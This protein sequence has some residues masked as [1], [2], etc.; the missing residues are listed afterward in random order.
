MLLLAAGSFWL[1]KKF[2]QSESGG[3]V[4]ARA[5][6]P[7]YTMEDFR[8]TSAGKDGKVSYLL[9]GELLSHYPD[10]DHS[11][12]RQPRLTSYSPDRPP[13]T[14]RSE[15]ARINGDRSEVHLHDK[16]LLRRP[17]A[18]GDSELTV[19]SEY[20]LLLTKQDLV[21]SDREVHAH[22]GNS[23]LVGTG[24]VADNA[25]R[26]LTLHSQVS[27]TFTQPPRAKP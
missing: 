15:S 8:Y 9:E 27:A 14:L 19:D 25:Q 24:M 11:I 3:P 4:P 23:S 26:T 13:M 2:Q 17:P 5:G 6:E 16:V 20:M 21:K 22:Q 7:D 12:V 10:T 18:R 1:L